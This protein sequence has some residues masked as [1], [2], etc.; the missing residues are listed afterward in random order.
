M[1]AWTIL[2]QSPGVKLAQTRQSSGMEDGNC[3]ERI[4][5]N[6]QTF[7]APVEGYFS[8]FSSLEKCSFITGMVSGT[9]L[10]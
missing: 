4:C 8:G 10:A 3:E 9:P 2:G 5:Q 1:M 6:F 7:Q